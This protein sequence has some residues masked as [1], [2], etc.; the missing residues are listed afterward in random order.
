MD[1]LYT[2]GKYLKQK[3][4]K[5]IKKVPISVPGFTCPNIDGTKAR[6]GCIFC[7]NESFS[8]NFKKERFTLNPYTEKNPILKKQLNELRIQYNETTKIY[9]NLYKSEKFIVYFQSFTNTYAPFDTLKTLYEEA[10]KLSDAIGLSIG[11]RADSIDDK[12]LNYLKE[13]SQ[14]YEIWVEYGVQSSNNKTL[15]KI[16]RAEFFEDIAQT[17]KKTKELGINV[18]AHLIFGLPG[19]TQEDMLKSVEDVIKLEIDS[20]KIHPLY[21][22]E[23]TLL[24]LEYKKGNFEPITEELYIDTLIKAIKMLPNNVSIQ[25]M[26][27][28]TE[29]LLAPEWCKNKATQMSHI[30]KALLKEG[31]TF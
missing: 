22:T 26:T 11:T 9:K 16:N 23:N 18:C 5:K 29:N 7:E 17:I 21:V 24:A 15:A 30:H 31:I 10:L 6:G 19:E 2:F 12:T 27:A 3:Y 1:K 8:P 28:G 20:I 25:R 13:K 14:D 4:N